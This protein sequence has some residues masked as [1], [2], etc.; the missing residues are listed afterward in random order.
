MPDVADK[1][2]NEKADNELKSAYWVALR[3]LLQRLLKYAIN[4]IEPIPPAKFS[5][6]MVMLNNT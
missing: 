2:V 1:V 4:T 6:K 3:F 5:K